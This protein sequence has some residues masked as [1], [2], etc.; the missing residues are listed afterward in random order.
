MPFTLLSKNKYPM[1]KKITIII[2]TFNRQKY[3]LRLMKYCS[4]NGVNAIV[5][6]G[7]KKSLPLISLK[8]IKKNVHYLHSQIGLI[9]R[10]KLAA[11]LVKTEYVKICNDDEFFIRSA[12]NSCVHKLSNSPDVSACFGKYL[13][14]DWEK[15]SVTGYDQYT[16]Q[17]K[18]SLKLNDPRSRIKEHFKNFEIASVYGVCRSNIWKIFINSLNSKSH[19]QLFELTF[20]LLNLFAGKIQYVP[21]LLHL[22]SNENMQINPEKTRLRKW[23]LS[24]KNFEKKKQYVSRVEKAIQKINKINK[25]YFALNVENTIDYYLNFN[26]SRYLDFYYSFILPILRKLPKF[27]K[28]FIKKILISTSDKKKILL[29]NKASLEKKNGTRID[30]GELKKI[31]RFIECFYQN[32]KI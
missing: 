21:E 6:D 25:I 31:I 7:S 11:T 22:R 16:L 3:V 5:V 17:D 28:E 23:W 1:L 12:L 15:N 14:F 8:K 30:L 29:I 19:T 2:P 32:K 4:E 20:E 13:L 10:L 18:I 26:E 9:R 27:L 24:K